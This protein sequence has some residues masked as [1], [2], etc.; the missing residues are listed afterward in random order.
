M[1]HL[2]HIH[3]HTHAQVVVEDAAALMPEEMDVARMLLRDWAIPA[4]DQLRQELRA[5]EVH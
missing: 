3:L 5:L 1:H 4:L 2:T